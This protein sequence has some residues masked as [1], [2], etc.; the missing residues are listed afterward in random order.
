MEK[1]YIL[2]GPA[3]AT[4]IFFFDWGQ[5]S[6][7]PCNLEARCNVCSGALLW[8]LETRGRT[9]LV[10]VCPPPARFLAQINV[11]LLWETRLVRFG[12]LESFPNLFGKVRPARI[13]SGSGRATRSGKRFKSADSHRKKKSS[14]PT[15][16]QNKFESV[17]PKPKRS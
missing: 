10:Q 13:F 2:Q 11:R 9:H 1:T 7:Y 5:I 8:R 16:T 15:R 3:F 17:D 14:R 6:T 4:F 12:R